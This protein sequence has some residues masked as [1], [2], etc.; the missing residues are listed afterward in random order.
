MRIDTF[1]G[2][3]KKL[4]FW[5]DKQLLFKDKSENVKKYMLKHNVTGIVFS[6]SWRKDFDVPLELV[7]QFD[8]SN[9]VTV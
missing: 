9:S 4:L 7:W 6:R 2:Q 8:G 3:T 1:D 5:E